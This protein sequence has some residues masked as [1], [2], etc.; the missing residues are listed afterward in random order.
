MCKA[1]LGKGGDVDMM[2]YIT[3]AGFVLAI[4]VAGIAVGK[5]VEKIE[6]SISKK[7]NEN[8]NHRNTQQNN[9]R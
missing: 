6:R 9:R 1:L 5:F 4:F 7:E 8:E 3:F 2:E